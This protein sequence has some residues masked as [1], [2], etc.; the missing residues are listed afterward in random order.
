MASFDN[1]GRLIQFGGEV[2]GDHFVSQVD[3]LGTFVLIKDEESPRIKPIRVDSRRNS[4]WKLSID[5]NLIS[6]GRARD[7]AIRGTV[8]GQWML[9]EYDMKNNMILFDDWEML[10]AG[11]LDLIIEVT[12][13]CG[14]VSVW[15]KTLP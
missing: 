14:N 12:D 4:P 15:Q 3:Q 9:W 6:D 2:L 8:N 11:A 10:P 5:D 13:H 7:L 1:K